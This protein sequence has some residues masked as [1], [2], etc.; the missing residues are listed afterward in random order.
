MLSSSTSTPASVSSAFAEAGKESDG[1]RCLRVTVGMR[2]SGHR[3]RS[4]RLPA[5]LRSV[6]AASKREKGNRVSCAV[7]ISYIT[8]V[9]SIAPSA[10]AVVRNTPSL[11]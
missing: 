6:S 2:P 3:E 8:A 10:I 5:H 4:K 11:G 7:D 9:P 1:R